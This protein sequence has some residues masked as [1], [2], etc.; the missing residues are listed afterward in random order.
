MHIGHDTCT[1]YHIT[2]DDGNSNVIEQIT[3]EKDLAVYITADLKPSTQCVRAAAI[4][5]SVMGMVR[6][7]FRR[8]D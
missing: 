3:E 7:N 5:R 8:L 4:A 1:E 2:D 6:R